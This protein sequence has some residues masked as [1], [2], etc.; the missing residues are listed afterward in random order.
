VVVQRHQ[1][2]GKK[3]REELRSAQFGLEVASFGRILD[4]VKAQ[5]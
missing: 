1:S 3:R 4:L 5:F 2:E